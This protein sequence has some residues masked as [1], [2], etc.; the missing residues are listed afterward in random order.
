MIHSGIYIVY[1]V[2]SRI[3]KSYS[4]LNVELDLQNWYTW[5]CQDFREF[6]KIFETALM[7]YSG[8]W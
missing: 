4:R 3:V 7:G 6:S 8:A 5:R 1:Y 2:D